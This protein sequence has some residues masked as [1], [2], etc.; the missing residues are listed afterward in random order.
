MR[1]LL[2]RTR[3]IEFERRLLEQIYPAGKFAS[4][5]NL[6]DVTGGS[7]AMKCANIRTFT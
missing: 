2:V 4:L 6:R 1:C 5:F 3:A 7:L